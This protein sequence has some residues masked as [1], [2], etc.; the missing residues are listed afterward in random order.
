MTPMTP[1]SPALLACIMIRPDKSIAA[2]TVGVANGGSKRW[3]DQIVSNATKTAI[4]TTQVTRGG[5]ANTSS[6]NR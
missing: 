6:T 1:I 4:A 3:P 5:M 2:S